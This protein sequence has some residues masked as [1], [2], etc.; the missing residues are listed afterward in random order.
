MAKVTPK[1]AAKGAGWTLFGAAL[2]EIV[3][4]LLD[5]LATRGR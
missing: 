4:V 2:S 5:L 3:R 1:G